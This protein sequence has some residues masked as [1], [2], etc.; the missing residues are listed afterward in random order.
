MSR[1]IQPLNEDARPLDPVYQEGRQ[2]GQYAMV[3]DPATRKWVVRG[4]LTPYDEG[5][6]SFYQRIGAWEETTARRILDF[7]VQNDVSM[8]TALQQLFMGGE[9]DLLIELVEKAKA[10]SPERSYR[11]VLRFEIEVKHKFGNHPEAA[12]GLMDV[13]LAAAINGLCTQT[14]V[15]G[16]HAI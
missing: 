8:R 10:E 6:N 4:R 11:T 9:P 15:I 3:Y 16:C 12:A 1:E 2:G 13:A 7:C 14:G 5:A